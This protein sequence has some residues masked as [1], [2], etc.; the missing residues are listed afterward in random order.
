MKKLLLIL[1]VCVILTG[2][3]SN[4]QTIDTNI[5]TETETI[6]QSNINEDTTLNSI[7]GD[8]EIPSTL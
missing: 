6:S 1:P 7:I 3:N 4:E 2:C 5:E 8:N